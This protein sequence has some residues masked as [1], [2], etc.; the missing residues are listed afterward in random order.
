MGALRGLRAGALAVLCVLLPLA[1]HALSQ[2]HAPRWTIVAG[3]AGVIIPGSVF[4]TRHRLSDTQLLGVLAGAQLAYHIAYS[5]PGACAAM[6]DP[7]G[8]PGLVEHAPVVGTPPE[9]LLAGHLVSLVIAARLLGVTEQILW[10][11][12]PLL[13]A[14]QRLLLFVWPHLR[15]AH[16]PLS[17]L[18]PDRNVSLPASAVPARWHAGRAPPHARRGVSAPAAFALTGPTPFGGPCMP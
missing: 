4:L 12:R 1:G 3:V 6:T 18:R 14:V 17:E 2:G 5:L 16:D 7:V 15:F 8:L 10:Q 9:V 11:S 13:R